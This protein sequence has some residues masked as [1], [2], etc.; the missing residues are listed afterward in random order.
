[1]K[2]LKL[3]ITS[4][5]AVL[6]MNSCDFLDVQD[7]YEETLPYDSVFHN[8]R[9][10]QKYLWNIPT[11]FPDEGAIMSDPYTPGPLATDEGIVLYSTG[12]FSGQGY[13]MGEVSPN[14]LKRFNNWGS[15]YRVIRRVNTL[16][17]RMDEAPDLEYVDR[18]EI[19]GYAK[20][21]RAYAYYHL[22]MHFGPVILV[23]DKIIENNEDPSYYNTYRATYDETV[24]YI[25]SELEEA[26]QYM[27]P[28]VLLTQ[29]G[30]PT[31]DAAY[32]LVARLR[33]IQAS[34]L[35]NGGAAALKYYGT[36][37]RSVDGVHYVSQVYDETKWA[38]AAAA[39]ERVIETGRYSLHIVPKDATTPALPANVP[40][41]EFPLGAGDIDPFKSYN[42]MFTGETVPQTNREF[43]WGRHSSGITRNVR[44]T[45]ARNLLDGYNGLALTQKMIDNYRMADGRDISESSALYPYKPDSMTT[46]SKSF[47]GYF[48][49][50]NVSGMY[51]NREMRFYACVGF[52]RRYWTCNSS[53]ET[54]FKNLTITYHKGGN[55]DKA[56]AGNNPIDYTLSGYVI[57]KWVHADDAYRGNGSRVLEKS[58]PIIRYAEI[59]LSYVEAMNNLT[60]S[61]TIN[62]PTGLN[63]TKDFTVSRD[64][65]KMAYNFNQ[66]RYRAGLPGL[67]TT[68]LN[69]KIEMQNLLVRE[70]MTEFLFENRR[71]FDVR[72]WGIYEEVDSQPMIGMNV[73]ADEPDFYTPTIMNHQ[74]TRDRVTHRK[75]I[76]LPIP[77]I[78]TERVK[79]LDQNP[80]WD[81]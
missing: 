81:N 49:N 6:V 25:C 76:L 70:R 18:F 60:Q 61:Y 24:D 71:Y 51:A 45:F 3:I 53:T 14:D 68:E 48:L 26:A 74:R 50:N 57:T 56:S 62:L 42:D 47:S 55:A 11:D 27:P 21:M 66:V 20:F 75:M 65:T 80:G 5:L 67:S 72:R 4:L 30:R 58:Y 7:Y 31:S 63:E 10:L 41:G 34:P 22:L 16:L 8:T 12:E 77:R 29:F 28:T 44:H 43:I 40:V 17:S 79:S 73:L 64:V 69:S 2:K 35:F 19:L 54:A 78:E 46:Q 37:T 39:C 52:N 38:V 15:M 1:M 33:L 23:G 32:A 36:W 59:L 13:V 9:N